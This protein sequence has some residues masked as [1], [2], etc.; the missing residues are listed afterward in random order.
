MY[1]PKK[2]S[3][4][5][6][7]KLIHSTWNTPYIKVESSTYAIFERKFSYPET[8]HTDGIGTKGIYHWKKKTFK[9]AVL[10]SLAM[11]LNDLLL[12]R[13]KAYKLQNHLVLPKDDEKVINAIVKS[14]VK[15]CK[16]RQIAITG[17]ETSIHNTPESFDI[18]ITI[19]G[20]VKKLQDNKARSGDIVVGLKSSG[21]HSNG[22]TLVRNLFGNTIR[23]EFTRPTRIYYDDLVDIVSQLK[24]H[25]MMHITG[26]AFSKLHG[27]IDNSLDVVIS[28]QLNLKPQ[29]IF[30][31]MFEKGLT[32][33]QM[34]TTFNCGVGFVL[35]IPK[36]EVS[37]FVK[38]VPYSKIIGEVRKGSGKVRIDS[39]FDGK[40]LIV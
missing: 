19:S 1:D 29:K 12:V 27:I 24:I 28:N 3:T 17:G 35:T 21:L 34:Y 4:N 23:P 2:P 11:N 33:R 38:H 30:F 36:N 31:E 10:D 9:E 8:D 16:K 5:S 6:V 26:G 7:L 40:S 37:K 14:L 22:F 13:A 18:A 39:A 20:F 25:G 32:N 15:E